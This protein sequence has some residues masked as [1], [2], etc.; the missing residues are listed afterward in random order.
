MAT[1][2]KILP[3][4]NTV[5]SGEMSIQNSLAE[6]GFNLYP[7]STKGIIPLR[8]SNGRFRT[9]LD[10][11]ALYIKQMI[12][13]EAQKIEIEKV[14]ERRNRLELA[15]GL[16]LDPIPKKGKDQG[17]ELFSD[18]NYYSGIYGTR[19]GT[20]DVAQ[21][22]KLI[23]GPNI[24]NFS[25]PRKEIEYWWVIQDP[26]IVPS[27][28]EWKKGH[29]KPGVQFYITNEDAEAAVAYNRNKAVQKASRSLEDMS[30]NR[31]KKVARLLALPIGDGDKEEIVFNHLFKF[32]QLD[33]IKSGPHQGQDAV[34]LFNKY[35]D[36]NDKV[37]EVQ[38]LVET[39]IR[40]RVYNINSAG[41]VLEGELLVADSKDVL[42]RNLCNDKKQVERITLESK[43]N[44][45]I[46]LKAN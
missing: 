14:T 37:L 27:L 9:G 25:D 20:Q 38:D 2:A 39:A 31:R 41:L 40:L 21:K 1:I 34:T 35:A 7:G 12:D 29:C 45:K 32:I 33:E 28:L 5:I 46:K 23:D 3:L 4:P 26:R 22:V 10:P 42:I 19:Y 44:D 13:P 36:L 16:D 24:F 18:Q 6:K 30:L 11:E 17:G 8:D 43:V 15:T